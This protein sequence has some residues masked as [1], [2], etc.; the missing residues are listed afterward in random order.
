[1]GED[2]WERGLL[3]KEAIHDC[4]GCANWILITLHAVCVNRILNHIRG[5]PH[6]VGE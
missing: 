1:M 4:R 3:E 6:Y 2:A 5:I